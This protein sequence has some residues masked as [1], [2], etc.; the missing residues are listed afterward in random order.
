MSKL[1]TNS[2]SAS[3]TTESTIGTRSERA[4]SENPN[5]TVHTQQRRH[6]SLSGRVC[7]KSLNKS[8]SITDITEK[9]ENIQYDPITK[10]EHRI[11]E[12][13][14]TAATNV[15]SCNNNRNL[16]NN[17]RED[18]DEVD[19]VCSSSNNST[20]ETRRRRLNIN[21]LRCE[22]QPHEQ[23]STKD[24]FLDTTTILNTT[25]S[26]V[27]LS[28]DEP[29]HLQHRFART[30]HSTV[31]NTRQASHHNMSS[32][33]NTLDNSFSDVGGC[34]SGMSS[35]FSSACPSTVSS[36]LSTPT[37]LSPQHQIYRNNPHQQ[38][39]ATAACCQKSIA[40]VKNTCSSNTSVTSQHNNHL[41]EQ[42][43]DDL[44]HNNHHQPHN[45]HFSSS[46]FDSVIVS[47]SKNLKKFD[48]RLGPSPYRQLLPIALCILSFATVFSILIVY[49]D[50][51]G[52]FYYFFIINIYISN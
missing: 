2:G 9:L 27:M 36:P 18:N 15:L 37:R 26:S 5:N 42:H 20:D 35:A 6:N 52:E 24:G 4:S 28:Y 29:D 22:Q 8:V 49:M 32:L 45:K 14:T 44:R 3:A 40:P 34:T 39:H 50:T 23:N 46:S 19:G 33:S 21:S 51:T 16:D 12:E 10:M 47:G 11:T 25:N 13:T 48:P 31:F 30:A 41:H 7:S 1:Y 43:N 38:H 17:S